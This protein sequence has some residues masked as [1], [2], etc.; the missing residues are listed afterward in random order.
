MAEIGGHR[1]P[2]VSLVRTLFNPITIAV[3]VCKDAGGARIALVRGFQKPFRG[4]SV[5]ARHPEA[6]KI[7]N[8]QLAF[9]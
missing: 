4:L 2:K 9:P 7:E 8:S 3:E 5:V 1:S 6:I